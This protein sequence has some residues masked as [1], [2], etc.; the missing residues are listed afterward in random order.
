MKFEHKDT[1]VLNFT[2]SDLDGVCA[3]IVIK[4]YY[5]H[6]ITQQINYGKEQDAYSF[7]LKHRNDFDLIIFTD[8]YPVN[9]KDFKSINKPVLVFDHHESA[10]K[11]NKPIEDIYVNIKYSG[12]M[13]AYKYF[14]T[15]GELTH[16][17]DLV[18]IANDFDLWIL[19]DNRSQFFNAIFWEMGFNWFF[20]RF[21]KGNTNL[22]AEER[23]YLVDY[24]KEYKNYYENIPVTDVPYNGVLCESDKFVSELSNSLRKDGYAWVMIIRGRSISVRSSTPDIDLNIVTRIVGK[25]GGHKAAAG[26]PIGNDDIK[27]LINNIIKAVGTALSASAVL[28]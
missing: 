21:L 10:V 11:Y 1:R 25:G 9:I 7:A 14:N 28:D 18:N 16:L 12:T 26:I 6:V 8:F 3:G 2:H 15:H 24:T 17:S 13:M 27:T 22:Y 4:N 5:H 19:K 23:E 20:R